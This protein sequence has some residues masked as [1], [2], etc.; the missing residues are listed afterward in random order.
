MWSAS[1]WTSH[2]NPSRQPIT[3]RPWLIASMVTELMTPLI[4][5]AGPPPTTSAS[6]PPAAIAAASSRPRACAYSSLV[7]D[8]GGG[9]G[10]KAGADGHA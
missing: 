2:L 3:S 5:G 1:P 9:G 8:R 7:D 6:L 10:F 4:P